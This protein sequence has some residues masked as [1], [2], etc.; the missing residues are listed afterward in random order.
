[1]PTDTGEFRVLAAPGVRVVG[2]GESVLYLTGSDPSPDAAT[3]TPDAVVVGDARERTLAAATD[4]DAP[5]YGP[6]TAG[7]AVD[8]TLAPGDG[9]GLDG[10]ELVACV[11][12]DDTLALAARVGGVTVLLT[13]DARLDGAAE[14]A[15]VD[16]AVTAL[17]RAGASPPVHGAVADEYPLYGAVN[18]L[19]VPRVTGESR[20][21]AAAFRAD[22]VLLDDR[23]F[24]AEVG[25]QVADA[26]VSV[27]ATR[28]AS[29]LA[30]DEDGVTVVRHPDP[31]AVG[32]VS[33]RSRNGF[34]V[35]TDRGEGPTARAAAR[36]LV[37]RGP[38]L[39][40]PETAG[41]EEGGM[42]PDGRYDPSG[43]L[44]DG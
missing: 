38:T 34:V 30:P 17:D 4:H 10:V 40:A 8:E 39:R 21:F 28:Y 41:G 16:Q 43:T 33:A 35:R 32:P 1:M 18:V 36:T 22:V 15:V 31:D 2:R 5:V 27:E 26:G 7:T 14:D 44:G 24:G 23:G 3:S 12:A 6:P 20:V 9:V 19:D 11:P 37:A 13:P 25:R 29:L 42:E